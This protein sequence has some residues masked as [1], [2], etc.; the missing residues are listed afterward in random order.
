MKRV[1]ISVTV[2]FIFTVSAFAEMSTGQ[3]LA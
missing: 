2:L 3:V 1:M